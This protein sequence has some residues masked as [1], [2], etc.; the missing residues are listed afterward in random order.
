MNQRIG[1]LL[2]LLTLSGCSKE[3]IGRFFMKKM[4]PKYSFTLD[5]APAAPE[6]SDSSSW[7]VLENGGLDVDI[8]YLHPTTYLKPDNWNQNIADTATNNFTMTDPTIQSHLSVFRGLGNLYVPKYRQATVYSF[9][10]VKDDGEKA[11]ALAYS[12]VKRA[13]YYYFEHFN[14]GKPFIIEA[15]SQGALHAM[16]LLTEIYR[17][18]G[19]KSK[20][21]AVYAAGWPVTQ[22][23]LDENPDIPFCKDSCQTGCLLGWLTEGKHAMYSMIKEPSEAVNPLT[24]KIDSEQAPATLNSGAILFFKDRTDTVEHY[25]SARVKDGAVIISKPPHEKRLYTPFMRGNF[26]MY[27]YSFFFLNIR[28][29]AKQR[30][31]SYQLSAGLIN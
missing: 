9:M 30:I 22:R 23:Y 15:H 14:K 4:K 11:L 8:F 19:I 24:W 12:D 6:Y 26:H 20:I 13:F 21:I 18:E 7:F 17:D 10:D 25:V 29:N 2:L 27:D 31:K 28:E 1:I 16:H 3:S 5:Q